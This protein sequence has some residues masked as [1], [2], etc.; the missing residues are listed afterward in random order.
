MNTN[1][2][3]RDED[4]FDFLHIMDELEASDLKF[5][6]QI[7]QPSLVF[8]FD[9]IKQFEK[10]VRALEDRLDGVAAAFIQRAWRHYRQKKAAAVVIQRAWRH[11][12]FTFRLFEALSDCVDDFLFN[13]MSKEFLM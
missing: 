12:R 6:E 4:S 5:Y 3:K 8:D 1:K 7:T 9:F 10:D 13:D 11:Y 2:R